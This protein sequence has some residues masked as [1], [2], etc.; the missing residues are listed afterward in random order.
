MIKVNSSERYNNYK[1][2]ILNQKYIYIP[3]QSTK[4]QKA[5]I[6]RNQGGN[7]TVVGDISDIVETQDSTVSN[8]KNNQAEHQQGNKPFGQYYKQT[9][10]KTNRHLKYTPH[11]KSWVEYKYSSQAHM[12]NFH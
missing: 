1:Y 5:K 6:D 7:S 8:G 4:I 3:N 9:R 12:E 11:N 10:I 2:I